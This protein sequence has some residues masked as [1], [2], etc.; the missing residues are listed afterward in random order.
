MGFEELSA[1]KKLEESIEKIKNLYVTVESFSKNYAQRV[2]KKQ[3][4]SDGRAA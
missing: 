2:Q 1:K 4:G 3:T